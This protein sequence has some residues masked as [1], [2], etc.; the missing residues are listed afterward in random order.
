ME[1]CLTVLYPRHKFLITF[2]VVADKS[3]A[4]LEHCPGRLLRIV[5]SVVTL[6]QIVLYYTDLCSESGQ[7]LAV[8][9]VVQAECTGEMLRHLNCLCIGSIHGRKPLAKQG[10]LLTGLQCLHVGQKLP[11]KHGLC[12]P[13]CRGIQKDKEVIP[14]AILS[15]IRNIAHQRRLLIISQP[16]EDGTEYRP[17]A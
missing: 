17:L 3:A 1:C 15:D 5:K 9:C 12:L 13:A 6:T 14:A 10:N 7:G 11:V 16:S 4:V 8:L 2:Q